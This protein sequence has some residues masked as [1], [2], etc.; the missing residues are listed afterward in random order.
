MLGV[1]VAEI[2]GIIRWALCVESGILLSE[3]MNEVIADNKEQCDIA[4]STCMNAT[5]NNGESSQKYRLWANGVVR[6][7]GRTDLTSF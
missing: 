2:T 6:K 7:W 1:P 3:Q 5:S 4:Q